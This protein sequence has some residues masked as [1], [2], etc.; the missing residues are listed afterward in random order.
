MQVKCNIGV[1][2]FSWFQ[3]Q[4]LVIQQYYSVLM[5]FLFAGKKYLLPQNQ[6][7]LLLGVEHTSSDYDIESQ[8]TFKLSCSSIVIATANQN[9]VLKAQNKGNHPNPFFIE[10]LLPINFS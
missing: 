8:Q 2:P 3:T 7:H 4:F 10:R 6:Y 5:D 9:A 1:S